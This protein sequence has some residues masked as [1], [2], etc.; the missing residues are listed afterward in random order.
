MARPRMVTRT[1]ITTEAVVLMVNVNTNEV[2]EKTVT[3]SGAFETK[4]D[5]EKKASKAFNSA[6]SKVIAVKSFEQKEALYGMD[7]QFFLQNAS[8]L[9][10]RE[11]T[12]DEA[13]EKPAPE[14]KSKK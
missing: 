11:V 5:V 4:E 1:I 13:E 10:P 3:L 7:E 12:E 6:E 9:P 14:K 2:F 8:I